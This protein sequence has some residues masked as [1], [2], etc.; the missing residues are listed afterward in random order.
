MNVKLI[1]KEP[2]IMEGRKVIYVI[3]EANKEDLQKRSNR[4]LN[5]TT[6]NRSM[7]QCVETQKVFDSMKLAGELYGIS[8]SSISRVCDNPNRIAGGYHWRKIK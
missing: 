1:P 8:Q 2:L 3:C 4:L 7:V 6:H 5:V